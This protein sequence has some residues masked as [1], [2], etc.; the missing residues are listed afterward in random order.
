[1]GLGFLCLARIEV[2]TAMPNLWMVLSDMRS[3]RKTGL[4]VILIL[5]IWI[6]RWRVACKGRWVDLIESFLVTDDDIGL[7]PFVRM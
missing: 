6:R 7:T 5:G 1:M 2:L 4:A 3:V